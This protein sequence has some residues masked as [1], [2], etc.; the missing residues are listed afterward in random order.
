MTGPAALRIRINGIVQG[1]GFRPFVHALAGKYGLRGHVANTASGVEI[2]AE[3]EEAALGGFSGSLRTEA[4]PLAHIRT[5]DAE[6]AVYRGFREF[7]IIESRDGAGILTMISPDVS[8]CAD[9]LREMQ[10]PADRRYRY[11]FINCTNCGPRYTIIRSLP[12]DRPFTTMNAFPLCPACRAEYEDPSD[13]RFHAQ[14]NACPVCGPRLRLLDFSGRDLVSAPEADADAA[15]NRSIRLLKDGKILAVK[16]LGGFHL[17]AD[18]E[19]ESAVRRLRERK[20]RVGKA[21]AVMSHDLADVRR[22]ALPVK[23]EEALLAGIQSP[24]V[25]L[26]KRPDHSLGAS[27]APD[28]ACFGVMLPYT[29]LHYLL[30][31]PDPATGEKP[32]TALVMTSANRSGEPIVKDNDAAMTALASLADAILLHDRDIHIRSDDSIIR[33]AAGA[34][35][36]IRRSRGYAPM[37]VFLHRELPRTLGVGAELKSTICLSRGDAAFLSPHIGDMAHLETHDFFQRTVA[38]LRE[39][40]DIRPDIVVHD[41]HPDYQSTRYA[42]SLSGPDLIGVQHHHAHILS[43]MAE[44]RIDGP[45]LGLAFDG[46]GYGTDGT[47]WGGELLVTE[48]AGFTRAARLRPVPLPGGDAAVRHPWRMALSLLQSSLGN[49]PELAGA[50]ARLPGWEKRTEEE[51]R[52]ITRLCDTGLN[53]PLTSSMGRLFDGMAALIGLRDSVSF[54]GQAAMEMEMTAAKAM[55]AGGPCLH[56]DAGNVI[57]PYGLDWVHDSDIW[58]LDTAPLVRGVLADLVNGEAKE[59]IAARFHQSLIIAWT[60]ITAEISRR[61]GIRKTVL[62]GGAFQN[63]I[64]LE[65]MMCGLEEK[66]MRVHSHTLV[67]TNDG[68]ISLGQVFAAAR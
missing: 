13:R 4:P 10:D 61:T 52:I 67:P 9:C 5:C 18:A 36:P 60:K 43:C 44:N 20:R 53:S 16:G 66:G 34:V 63:R 54:D 27:V 6:A 32:F 64:L 25:L 62:S 39:V 26:E 8:V 45:V 41:L 59:V 30:L 56:S 24:I 12:Y 29:P 46:T 47:I 65:G 11:P 55:S 48:A 14:P 1:V 2:H 50:L 15:V 51:I 19:N 17:A 49:G 33:H 22:Y 3:G 7:S 57:R 68:G 42:R 40:L 58:E 35:R 23:E 38:H 28:N 37:P 31:G 21:F